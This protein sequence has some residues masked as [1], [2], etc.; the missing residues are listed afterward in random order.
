MRASL[1]PAL[2]YL[3][4]LAARLQPRARSGLAAARAAA[5]TTLL[6]DAEG[7]TGDS[8]QYEAPEN[9]DLL[10]VMERRRGLPIALAIL[11]VGLARRVG[12][13]AEVLGVPGH[14]LVAVGGAGTAIVL[15][16]F[17]DGRMLSAEGVRTIAT[18]TIG[19]HGTI[20][21]DHVAPLANREALVRLLMNP[22]SRAARQGDDARAL[23]LY[24]RM[25]LV[26][27]SMPALWWER[28]RLERL[29]GDT[30]AARASLAAMLETT[31]D[32]ALRSRIQAAVDALTR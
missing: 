18:K 22:A 16:P 17:N 8:A 30:A 10:S 24:R 14:V 6:A 9:A 21:R 4:G 27:P 32:P 20:G 25:T 11:Y 1:D 12:W 7:F 28:A 3:D 26:A 2:S 31:R 13:Q 15:D 19:R 29:A 23:T 5:L